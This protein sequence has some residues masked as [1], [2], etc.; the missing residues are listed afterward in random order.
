[1]GMLALDY[2]PSDDDTTLVLWE[3]YK[4]AHSDI[5]RCE[6]DNRNIYPAYLFITQMFNND[7]ELAIKSTENKFMQ[8]ISAWRQLKFSKEHAM[9]TLIYEGWFH[10]YGKPNDLGI[11]GDSKYDIKIISSN[12]HAI[13]PKQISGLEYTKED[14]KN[15]FDRGYFD[16]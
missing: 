4:I 2:V 3:D 1:S 15:L 13:R 11:G 5:Y 7:S 10:R 6:R 12:L 9:K 8:I 16:R 14:F